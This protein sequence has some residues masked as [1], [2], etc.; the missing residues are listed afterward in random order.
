LPCII[1]VDIDQTITFVHFTGREGDQV[2]ASPDGIADDGD[3]VLLDRKAHLFDVG[4]Q[5]CHPFGIVD[6]FL[7]RR[8]CETKSIFDNEKGYFQIGRFDYAS[9]RGCGWSDP[10]FYSD[11]I[12]F[13]GRH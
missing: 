9:D 6:L 5:I 1:P 7:I 8:V 12:S 4:G 2:D 10:K 13:G 3:T 11:A